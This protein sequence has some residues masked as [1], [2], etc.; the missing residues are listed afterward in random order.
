MS[1]N[2]Q[3]WL[4]VIRSNYGP[5]ESLDGLFYG[6][7]QGCIVRRRVRAGFVIT[8]TILICTTG[9]MLAD[10]TGHESVVRDVIV[11]SENSVQQQT[12]QTDRFLDAYS[13]V[14]KTNQWDEEHE[15]PF[16]SS[17]AVDIELDDLILGEIDQTNSDDRPN[18]HGSL[19]GDMQAVA[20]LITIINT[21]E[22]L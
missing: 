3:R 17:D 16:V 8:A 7:V 14:L 11:M 9:L 12:A 18:I 2:D 1:S 21:Q 10:H 22:T 5:A 15:S 19:G 20:H 4:Y 13:H 6:H